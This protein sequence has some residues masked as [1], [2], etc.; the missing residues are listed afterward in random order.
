[1]LENK[2]KVLQITELVGLNWV[3]TP[4]V[5]DDLIIQR[6]ERERNQFLQTA[7]IQRVNYFNFIR[8]YKIG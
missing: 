6:R 3:L 4:F 8:G 1:M 5:F 7:T 2:Q